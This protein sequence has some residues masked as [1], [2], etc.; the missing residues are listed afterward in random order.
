M[1]MVLFPTASGTTTEPPVDEVLRPAMVM[2]WAVRNGAAEIVSA[3]VV[4]TTFAML[5][6]DGKLLHPSIEHASA[7][8]CSPGVYD[9]EQ[10]QPVLGCEPAPQKVM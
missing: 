4:N 7:Q 8:F 3:D 5:H 9:D 6:A 10:Q 1:S 2:F